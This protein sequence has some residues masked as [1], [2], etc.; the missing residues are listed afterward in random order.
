[1][2]E[3]IRI[4]K[5][6][7]IKGNRGFPLR[8]LKCGTKDLMFSRYAF[9]S[10]G[11]IKR[12]KEGENIVPPEPQISNFIKQ[13]IEQKDIIC[14]VMRFGFCKCGVMRYYLYDNG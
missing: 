2:I 7:K 5:I 12:M 14:Y 4:S 11:N 8:C 9:Y 13:Q 6:K 10:D 3:I 1:M